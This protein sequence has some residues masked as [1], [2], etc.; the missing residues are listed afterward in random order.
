MA[1][2]QAP[3][4]KEMGLLKVASFH[5]VRG[6]NLAERV[7][8]AEKCI[9]DMCVA[10]RSGYDAMLWAYVKEHWVFWRGNSSVVGVVST[11]A[12]YTNK[13]GET[14][15][16]HW[17]ENREYLHRADAPNDTP[18]TYDG[19]FHITPERFRVR[20]LIPKGKPIRRPMTLAEMFEPLPELKMEE[21]P[22]ELVEKPKK[23]VM[24]KEKREKVV[25]PRRKG[26]TMEQ[27]KERRIEAL[28]DWDDDH[29]D[30]E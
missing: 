4:S 30:E 20:S 10:M 16:A 13:K 11:I 15:P 26:E 3:T 12:D 2:Q 7:R 9:L 19:Y 1:N 18:I 22:Y 23:K 29:S 17:T 25:L 6:N 14:F 21:K 5:K 27:W 24:K 8:D 28:P